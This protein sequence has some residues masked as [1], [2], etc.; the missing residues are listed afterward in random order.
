MIYPDSYQNSSNPSHMLEFI[1]RQVN[2]QFRKRQNLSPI[3][4]L[5]ILYFT[6]FY[7]LYKNDDNFMTRHVI[8]M[9]IK[10]SLPKFWLSLLFA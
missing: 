7:I 1:I 3:F 2:H 9:I 6:I 8:L 5:M 10:I 4:I